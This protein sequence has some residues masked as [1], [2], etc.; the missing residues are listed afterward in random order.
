MHIPDGY[1]SP[2]TYLPLYAVAALALGA[3]LRRMRRELTGR[4]V[5]YLAMA[6]AFAFLIQMFNVPIPGGATGHA[7]RTDEK[8]GQDQANQAGIKFSQNPVSAPLTQVTQTTVALGQL[9]DQLNLPA[10]AI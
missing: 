8:V 7:D 10:Y 5:P 6:A 4:H 9:E 3:G 1:L 2:Q